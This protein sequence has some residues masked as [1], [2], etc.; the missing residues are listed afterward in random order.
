MGMLTQ[1]ILWSHSSPILLVLL[2]VMKERHPERQLRLGTRSYSRVQGQ[3]CRV[4][5]MPAIILSSDVFPKQA[6]Y[7]L[8]V[9]LNDHLCDA[10]TPNFLSSDRKGLMRQLSELSVIHT[11]ASSAADP[12]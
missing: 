6:I 1:I 11:E 4:P 10:E 7:R 9:K 2:C 3:E 5:A 8:N 12:P